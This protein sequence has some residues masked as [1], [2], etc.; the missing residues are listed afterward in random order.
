MLLPVNR[1]IML[2]RVYVVI[3]YLHYRL[4]CGK[5]SRDNVNLCQDF[6]MQGSISSNLRIYTMPDLTLFPGWM[7]FPL[8]DINLQQFKTVLVSANSGRHEIW[9]RGAK[10]K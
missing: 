8:A 6:W 4:R 2:L 5:R 3:Y 10:Y 7:Q 1:L 9:C